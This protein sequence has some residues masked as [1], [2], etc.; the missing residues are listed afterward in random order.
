MMH[1]KKSIIAIDGHSSCGKSTVAKDLAKELGYV[2]IDT[3]AMYRSVTLFAMQNG[4]IQ[5]G[6]IDEATLKDRLGEINISFK[7]QPEEKKN[8]AFLNGVSVE[9]EIRSLE[10][11]SNVS[12][13]SAIGFVRKK[14]VELQQEM[15]KEGGIVMDG[16]DI[17]TVVFPNADLKLFMTASPEIRAQ[18]RYDEL[19]A[20]GDMVEFDAILENV[21][22]RDYLD[23]TR[24][25]SPL[26]QAED[27]VVLDN[28]HLNKEE[29]LEWIIKVLKE[30]KL[31]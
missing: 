19:T 27:A 25:E 14:L 15:G 8:E 23:S 26:I 17:G 20:K 11:S 1:N 13:I 5:N 29:Q 30:R 4:L 3:G 10:V 21:K 12:A 31:L 22:Q 28:S 16:R 18:R 7:Y 6:N 2:Y 24:E 9:D